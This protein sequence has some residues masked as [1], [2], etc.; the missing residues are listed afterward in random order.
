MNKNRLVA[1]AESIPPAGEA[2]VQEYKDKSDILC[3]KMNEFM[4]NRPD[5]LDLIGGEKNIEMM[6]DNH[7]NHLRFIA[8]ILKAPDPEAL[9]ETVLWVFKSYMSRG[10]HSNYWPA[11]INSWITLLKEHLTEKSFKE[12]IGIYQW[13]SVNIPYFGKD[14]DCKPE[15]SQHP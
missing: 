2:A 14:V 7:A 13:L 5:I 8:S 11:Q 1:S 12:I 9:T 4:L 10:F 6:K 15:N 3:A